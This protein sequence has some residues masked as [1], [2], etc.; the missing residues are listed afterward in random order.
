MLF[1]GIHFPREGVLMAIRWYIAYPLSYNH[2]EEM[3]ANRGIKVDH[4][5]L[6]RWVLKYTPALEEQALNSNLDVYWMKGI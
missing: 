6:H 5:T 4:A 3:L 2:I 1:K